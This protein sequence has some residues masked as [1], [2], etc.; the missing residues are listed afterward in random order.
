[1][2]EFKKP[3]SR[4]EFLA[5]FAQKKPL[6]D[7]NE[8]Y[9]E[10]ARCLFCYD[11]P[12][13]N[14]CP[15]GIDIPLFIKQIHTGNIIG[16]A[17]TIYQYNWMGNACGK[18]C[19]TEELCEGACV[20]NLQK[21]KPIE[22]GR[23]QN[24]ATDAAMSGDRNLFEPGPDNGRK[25]AIIG[26]GPAGIACAAELRTKGYSVDVFE[27]KSQPS[28]L[29]LYGVAPYKITNEEAVNEVLWLQKQLGFNIF[30]NQPIQDAE[31]LKKL[32]STYD[33]IFLGVG[34]GP[35][36]RLNIEGE[37]LPHVIGA[38]EFVEI[39]RTKMHETEVP[40]RVVVIGGGNTA[41]DVASESARMGAEQVILV[42]RRGRNQMG[43]YEFEYQTI[44]KSGVQTRF[45][46]NPQKIT[47]SG[48]W[49]I[50]TEEQNGKL[51][52]I[53]GSAFFVEAD[54]VIKATGQAKCKPLF[55]LIGGLELNANGTIKVNHRYQTTQPAYFAGGDAV[56]GGAEVVN[57]AFEGKMAAQGIHQW[58]NEKTN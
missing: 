29:N 28:G 18:V 30:Y 17:Q 27:A 49:F 23:L 45:H 31:T 15:T 13:M 38:V 42:Y 47:E 24:F 9:Y 54:L 40:P 58:L 55:E 43:A 14:A 4:A 53:P 6:M 36:A 52:E 51:Q 20:H 57:G 2:G 48:V 16:A 26:A 41:M 11:A 10:S 35:T 3:A 5:N 32:E 7:K 12:C 50:R 37:D 56:N 44:L 33:A 34:L 19:P 1:M 21:V 39:L 8:A 46:A 25:V 22:I